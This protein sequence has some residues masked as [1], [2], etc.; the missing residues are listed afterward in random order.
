MVAQKQRVHT[1]GH[2]RS[3]IETSSD[4]SAASKKTV[5]IPPD[6]EKLMREFPGSVLIVGLVTGGIIGW[7]TSKL[8]R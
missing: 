1:N 3:A 2:H 4:I 5:I 7:L 8:G 6:V